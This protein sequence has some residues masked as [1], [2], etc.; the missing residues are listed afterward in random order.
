MCVCV[1]TCMHMLSRVQ[2]F[3]TPWIFGWEI[4]WTEKPDGLQPTHS[5]RV[6]H[7]WA[8]ICTHTQTHTS[9]L[10]K[11]LF[12]SLHFL[13]GLLLLLMLLLICMSY[14]HILKIQLMSIASFVNIFFQVVNLWTFHFL[15]GF[16]FCAKAYNFAFYSFLVCVNSLLF[17]FRQVLLTFLVKH[18]LWC[19]TLSFYLSLKVF[20]SS[21]TL[22][23][24]FS[25]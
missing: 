8:H 25:R 2:L 11:C 19:W 6:G 14:L 21:S 12:R 3:V 18:V 9:S 16:F 22:N 20:I 10:E 15:Y 24:S 4:P 13:I 7:N 17:L 23:D 1:C 5:Q